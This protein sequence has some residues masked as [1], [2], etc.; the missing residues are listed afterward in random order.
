MDRARCGARH[1]CWATRATREQARAAASGGRSRCRGAVEARGGG[2]RAAWACGRRLREA[3]CSSAGASLWRRRGRRGGGCYARGWLQTAARA[4]ARVVTVGNLTVGGT[5]KTTLTLH[6]ARRARERG[7]R[8]ARGVPA[9][10]PR[11]RTGAATRSGST[12]WRWVRSLVF[13]GRSQAGAGARA[14]ARGPQLVLVDDGFSHWSARARLDVVLLD[15]RDPWGGGRLLPAGRLREPR[16][17]LQRAEAVVLTRRAPAG[18]DA[19][20]ADRGRAALRRPRRCSAA[21]RHRVS[22]V[23]DL[24]GAV[25]RRAAAR[26]RGDRDRQSRGGGAQRARE[27]AS[28]SSGASVVPRPSLVQRRGGGARTPARAS[29]SARVC[30]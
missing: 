4:S 19:A 26:A 27:P 29:A 18:G 10:P 1:C 15:A 22:G 17:A 14:A 11:T 20:A 24:A 6:L 13:A 25:L 28:R 12:S 3:P 7:H 23:R 8:G 2:A 30:C 21:A 16:R 5:G 9:L